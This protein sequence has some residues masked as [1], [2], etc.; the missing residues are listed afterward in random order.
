MLALTET[1]PW[2]QVESLRDALWKHLAS[3]ISFK[4]YLV[5]LCVIKKFQGLYRHKLTLVSFSLRT[6]LCF[7]WNFIYDT[8]H[9]NELL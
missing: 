9:Y 4:V 7:I 8:F 1:A 6:S 5:S 2:H 3:Q